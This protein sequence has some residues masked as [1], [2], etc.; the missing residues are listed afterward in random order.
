MS[1]GI[2]DG[3][4]NVR[5]EFKALGVQTEPKTTWCWP[6]AHQWSRWSDPVR[7][8]PDMMFAISIQRRSCAACNKSVDRAV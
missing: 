5:A 8:G 1:D 3:P 4:K 2:F 7:N 6:W